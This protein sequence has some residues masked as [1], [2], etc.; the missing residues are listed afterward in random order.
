MVEGEAEGEQEH[1][2][3]SVVVAGQQHD[4]TLVAVAVVE[5][6]YVTKANASGNGT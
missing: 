6:A 3:D 1:S 5:A 4:H 2:L